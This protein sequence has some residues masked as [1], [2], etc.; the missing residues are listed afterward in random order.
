MRKCLVALTMGAALL[1]VSAPARVAATGD[2]DVPKDKQT[3]PGLYLTAAE[4]YERWKAD[5]EG[6]KILDVRT[7]DEW[8]FVGHAEMAWNVPFMLQEYRWDDSGRKL[9]MTP[10]PAFLAEVKGL[11]KPTDTVLVMCRSGNRSAPAV[12]AIA[13]AGYQKVYNVVDGME[14][15]LVNDPASPNHG[16]RTKNG[17]KNAG[18]PWTYAL[19]PAKMR[20]PAAAK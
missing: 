16:K 20:L 17:W 12:D 3:T 4:A 11:F 14:G 15:D 5:P 6:V 13:A 9:R 19:D 18:L 7:P 1:C 10:N 2:G 8:L